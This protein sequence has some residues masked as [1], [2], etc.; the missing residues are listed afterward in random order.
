M[1]SRAWF[2]GLALAVPC[3]LAIGL[4][5]GVLIRIVWP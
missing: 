3:W 2:F 5:V 4:L 1:T